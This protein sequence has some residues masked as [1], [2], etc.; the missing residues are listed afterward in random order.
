MVREDDPDA[1]DSLRKQ[2]EEKGDDDDDQ[3]E[4]DSTSPGHRFLGILFRSVFQ[5]L[6]M[7]QEFLAHTEYQHAQ[8]SQNN[9]KEYHEDAQNVS[10]LPGAVYGHSADFDGRSVEKIGVTV[11]GDEDDG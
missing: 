1:N 10:D 6:G 4:D 2:T 5:E 8:D 11:N 9:D 3:H 7:P